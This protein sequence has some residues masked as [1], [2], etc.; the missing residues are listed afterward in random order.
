[1]PSPSSNPLYGSSAGSAPAN[2]GYQRLALDNLIRRELKVSDPNDPQQIA[3]ALLE[4]FKD[5]PRAKA[6]SQEAKGLPFLLSAPMN[7]MP[8]MQAPTSSDA[9]LQQAKKDV[10][11]DLQELLTN[12]LL[13]DV[14]PE[15][16]G[17]AQAIRSAIQ[18]GTTS[19]R[20]ALDPR[21]RDKAFAIRRQLGDYAR[22]ARL[23]GALTPTMSLTYRKFAQ[24][25]D[26]VAAVILV[27][28][29]ESLANV[30]FNGG[31]FLL[32]APYS[33]LQVRR[34]AVIY[35]L[36]NLIG[37][38]QEAY[39]QNVWPRG[40][41]AYR[42]LFRILEDQGQGDLRSLLLENELARVMDELIQ[43]AAYGRAEGLRA[44]GATA[45]VDLER[46][47]RLVIIG[48]RAVSPESPPLT[49]FLE[50]LALF[51]D[52]FEGSGGFRLMRIARPPILFYGLYGTTTLDDA[53][54]TLLDLIIQRGLL[55]DEL[56]CFMQ[57]GCSPDYVRCQI[58][59]DKILYDVDR[60]ID[61]YAVG[62]TT[63]GQPERRAAAYSFLIEY[64]LEAGQAIGYRCNLPPSLSNANPP[65]ILQVIQAKL[66]PLLSLGELNLKRAI[67][68][69]T[70][71]AAAVKQRITEEDLCTTP[72]DLVNLCNEIQDR[73]ADLQNDTADQFVDMRNLTALFSAVQRGQ[74]RLRQHQVDVTPPVGLD[75]FE[76]FLGLVQQE[77]C[78]QKATEER[79]EN[80]VK[81]MAP[82]CFGLDDVFDMLGRL[83]D[84]AIERVSGSSC[85]S[86]APSIPPHFETSLDSI[87]ADVDRIGRGRPDFNDVD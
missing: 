33:E 22:L 41:D 29:G 49:A 17:W 24:S 28:M 30:G 26:E 65:G 3:N 45:Q 15:I 68:E 75:S 7:G 84:G 56:D 13:K 83:I 5:D 34:D 81:T 87:V 59:L 8:V 16:Q 53:D 23:V 64:F 2:S 14:T 47:R 27:T 58:I 54:R 79:W 21:Q 61:L 38:T 82:N 76:A 62:K 52:A 42:G 25:L 73:T 77:L 39:G 66:R 50:A 19:A 11:R 80:L 32:Q 70:A 51:A 86:T 18:E 9:E 35:A 1:M 48:R 71:F 40:L 74:A 37:A 57:C 4:R 60:A 46:F 6:I 55:A 85:P 72:P 31:R 78:I 63:F 69:L 43:R 10:D 20:F 36:R 12:P 67:S 44:L